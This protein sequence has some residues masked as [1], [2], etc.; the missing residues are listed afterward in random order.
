MDVALAPSGERSGGVEVA[1]LDDD[2]RTV[3]VQRLDAADLARHV[4]RL[5]RQGP[6]WV[7]AATDDVYPRLLSAGVRVGRCHDLRRGHAILTRSTYAAGPLPSAGDERWA[8]REAAAEDVAPTLLDVV[9]AEV[10][11]E[12]SD[13]LAEHRAQQEAVEAS[14]HPA[15]L[16][17]L[18]AAESAGTLAA[19]ELT[20]VGLPFDAAEH[21][22][23]L[24]DLL[25]PRPLPGQR[26]PVMEE[27]AEQV[28][29][30][31]DAPALNPDSAPDL[32]R[33]LRSAGVDVESTRQW[34]LS[35]S[36][37]PAVAPLLEYKKLARLHGANGWAWLSAWVSGGRFRPGY[38]PSGVVT[39]RWAARGGGALQLPKQVRGAVVAGPGRVLVVADA[40]QLEPRVLAAMA[41]DEAMAAASRRGDLYQALVDDKVVDTRAHAKVAM[42]GALYGA[43][44]GESGRL[45]P[46]LQRSYPAATGYV[47][48]AARAGE[49]G[50]VVTTWLGRSSPAPSEAWQD[51]QRWSAQPEADPDERRTARTQ[52]R[53]WGRFTRN[54][55]V[56]GTA[57]EWALCWLADLRRELA[58]LG[59]GGGTG[60]E[61][62]RL[63]YFLHDEVMVEAPVGLAAAVVDAVRLSARRAGRLLFG[64]F[65][66]EFALDVQVVQR[67]S[68]AG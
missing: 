16:R 4:A 62:A 67:Y 17:L 47:E 23:L 60:A 59:G 64:T 38:V 30:A 46:R 32:L 35:R 2:G 56:Q 33:A 5:E 36:D 8:P 48:A 28:R 45:L 49:A 43:T 18:L 41:R 34:E 61:D 1:E 37:H 12:L 19:A 9:D 21:D 44:S 13:V 51:A 65:P 40:A 26:P 58:A 15:R 7:W 22:R 55:V 11:L 29:T 27:L 68:E 14:A 63:V 52:A 39:G 42:L 31:L 24:T 50:E 6:R 25:G 54:F 20:H 57:A 53:E 66:V 3:R 10:P